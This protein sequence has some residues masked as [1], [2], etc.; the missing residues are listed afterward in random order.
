MSEEKVWLD[1]LG[2]YGDYLEAKVGDS[3]KNQKE[4]LDGLIDKIVVLVEYGEDRDKN[5]KQIGHK[6]EV[7]FKVE[8]VLD[9]LV[10]EEED[11]K[12]KGYSIKKGSRKLSTKTVN[13]QKGRGKKKL[14]RLVSNQGSNYNH[15]SNLFSNNGHKL[16]GA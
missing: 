3:N 13:L 16:N 5:I 14:L 8:V 12:S 1:W 4:W 6:F 15:R 10:Y 9:N 11:D 2:R 7:F